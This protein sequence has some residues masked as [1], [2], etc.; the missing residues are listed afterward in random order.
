[1]DTV[2]VDFVPRLLWLCQVCRKSLNVGRYV[3]LYV[4]NLVGNIDTLKQLLQIQFPVQDIL[5][6][7]MFDAD[8]LNGIAQALEHI[9]L[10]GGIM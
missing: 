3:L 8:P 7:D 9:G 5:V 1:M 2:F 10:E 4:R 6:I